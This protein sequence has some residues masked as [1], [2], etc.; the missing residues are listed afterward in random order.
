[1][2]KEFN[3][4]QTVNNEALVAI[5]EALA[6]DPACIQLLEKYD[7]DTASIRTV[8]DVYTFIKQVGDI[9]NVADKADVL[10]ESL[11]ERINIVIHKLK[12]IGED[13]KPRVWVVDNILS[14]GAV[15]DA[16]LDALVR[17]A[18][19]KLPMVGSA[20]LAPE[21]LL[22]IAKEKPL[23][24]LLHVLP[25]VLDEPMWRETPAVKNNRV[26][27]LDGRKRLTK[28]FSKVADDVEIL[29]EM[30]YPTYFVYGGNGESWM[31]F[32]L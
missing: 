28:D 10:C 23:H 1:M 26:F 18:G 20:D 22:I 12:F 21:L 4:Q 30:L 6:V 29:A 17:T 3:M 19:G 9:L 31:Q 2:A 8:T 27:L 25:S 5:V 24:E 14:A 7:L 13:Q 32:E 16:Y 11:E 15:Q